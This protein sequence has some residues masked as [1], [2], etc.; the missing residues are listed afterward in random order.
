MTETE[1]DSGKVL[2][3]PADIIVCIL[4][5]FEP[6]IQSIGVKGGRGVCVLP[7]KRQ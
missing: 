4:A 1:P 2:R 7:R 6:K 5:K 3:R